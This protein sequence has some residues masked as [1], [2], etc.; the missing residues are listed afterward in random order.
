MKTAILLVL[1]FVLTCSAV[2]D[3]APARATREYRVSYDFVDWLNQG[4][5]VP[6]KMAF[7]GPWTNPQFSAMYIPLSRN[8]GRLIV[9][10]TPAYLNT[11]DQLFTQW[12]RH[13]RKT[14]PNLKLL[15]ALRDPDGLPKKP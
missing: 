3:P 9:R 8:D 1:A 4:Y 2:D 7:P 14:P 13:G 15:E 12:Q 11:L 10:F 6:C 5:T